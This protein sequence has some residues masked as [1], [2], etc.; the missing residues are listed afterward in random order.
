MGPLASK[1]DLESGIAGAKCVTGNHQ[2]FLYNHCNG[3]AGAQRSMLS[4]MNRFW[5]CR[6]GFFFFFFFFFSFLRPRNE[7]SDRVQFYRGFV[8]SAVSSLFSPPT[9][10]LPCCNRNSLTLSGGDELPPFEGYIP[11]P[12]I[13]FFLNGSGTLWMVSDGVC[14]VIL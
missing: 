9:F 4:P 10:F 12:L 5:L 1:G 11:S 6:V 3:R 8:M 7:V 14:K 13:F 2:C